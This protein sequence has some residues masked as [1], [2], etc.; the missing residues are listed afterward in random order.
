M[1][2]QRAEQDNIPIHVMPNGDIAGARGAALEAFRNPNHLN[3]R[4]TSCGRTGTENFDVR[5]ACRNFVEQ[6]RH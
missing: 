5:I 4:P 2:T 1:P 3:L 6:V